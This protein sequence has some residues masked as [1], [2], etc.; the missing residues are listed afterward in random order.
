MFLICIQGGWASG[1]C[2][3]LVIYC[4]KF[5]LRGES[6]RDYADILRSLKYPPNINISDIPHRF[7]RHTNNTVPGFFNPNDGRLFPPNESNIRSYKDDCLGSQILLSLATSSPFQITF[8]QQPA[9]EIVT[10]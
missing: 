3:H 8:I 9:K 1:S 5:V 6:P 2:P 10:P 7:A 4:L